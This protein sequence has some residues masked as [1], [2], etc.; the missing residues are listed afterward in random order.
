MEVM[1]ERRGGVVILALR[2]KLDASTATKLEE[3]L[4]ALIQGGDRQVIVSGQ[5]LD[6]SSSAGLR[7]LLVAAKRLKPLNG[8]IVLS[9]LKAQI[10][11][12]FEIAG[13]GAIFPVYAIDEEALRSFQ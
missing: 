9:S 3:R 7:V 6:Y 12:V 4:L 10:Q 1:E 13:F 5:Q 8:R 2:G 11:E